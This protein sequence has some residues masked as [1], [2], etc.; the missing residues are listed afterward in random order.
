MP[1]ALTVR[2]PPARLLKVDVPVTGPLTLKLR[3]LVTA[4][5]SVPAFALNVPALLLMVPF[6][7][8]LLLMMAAFVSTLP[9][10]IPV[11]LLVM[12]PAPVLVATSPVH[13]LLLRTVPALLS[14]SLT[15]PLLVI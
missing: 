13:V 3:P 10:Q 12:L 11:V 14:A 15:A 8:P 9:F 4:P 2:M 1:A 7:V 5:F 6:Q